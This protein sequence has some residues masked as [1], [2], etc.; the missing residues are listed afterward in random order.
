MT[1]LN[2]MSLIVDVD[3]DPKIQTASELSSNSRQHLGSLFL[4]FRSSVLACREK[5]F[6]AQAS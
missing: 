1:C 5:S 3:S 6:Q 4:I 2:M